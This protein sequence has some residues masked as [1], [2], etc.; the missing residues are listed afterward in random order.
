MIDKLKQIAF[1]IMNNYDGFFSEEK[2]SYYMLDCGKCV[3]DLY[4]CMDQYTLWF[5]RKEQVTFK[6]DYVD[7]HAYKRFMN[8]YLEA[9]A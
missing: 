9:V 2:M 8:C 1:F 4:I 5:N 3:I 7:E 6:D